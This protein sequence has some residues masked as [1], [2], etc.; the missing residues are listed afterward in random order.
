MTKNLPNIIRIYI[1]R[2]KLRNTFIRKLAEVVGGVTEV[3]VWG[4]WVGADGRLVRDAN[5]RIEAWFANEHATEVFE[6]VSKETRRLHNAGEGAV[7]V[8]IESRPAGEGAVVH[9]GS[10]P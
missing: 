3:P 2:P 6:L 10:R 8:E 7:L 5:I 1:P 4:T 9:F